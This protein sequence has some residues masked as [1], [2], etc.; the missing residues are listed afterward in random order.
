[1]TKKELHTQVRTQID[2]L[3][4]TQPK[5]SKAF[6]ESL[7]KIIDTNLAPKQGGGG[8]Q[9]PPKL[10]EDG[11]IVEA[12]C[13]FHQRYEA[14]EAM[15][16]SNGKSKGYCKAGISAWNKNQTKVKSLEAEALKAIS[17]GDIETAQAKSKEAKETKESLVY[18]Y[19]ADWETFNS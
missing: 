4:N 3:L 14:A 11:N 5:L 6:K 1:M 2:E 17:E 18:D 16:I 10:D 19:E 9:N 15:V 8:S 7:V 13:R 12:F